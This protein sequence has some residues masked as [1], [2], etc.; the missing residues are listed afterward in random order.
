LNYII[1]IC[2]I[3]KGLAAL[4]AKDE[5]RCKIVP[6]VRDQLDAPKNTVVAAVDLGRIICQPNKVI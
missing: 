4:I 1:I 2:G 3:A 6:P 5:M